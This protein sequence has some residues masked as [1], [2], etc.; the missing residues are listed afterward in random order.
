MA[1]GSARQGRLVRWAS[2]RPVVVAA[3][4]YAILALGFVSP[5]LFT[6]RT[7]S[8]SDLLWF[9]TPYATSKPADL[10]RPANPELYDEALYFQPWLQ[11]TRAHGLNTPLW[12]PHQLAGEPLL[13]TA[14][15]TPYAPFYLPIYLLPFWTGLAVA[16]ALKL[17]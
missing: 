16:A 15:G 2:G 9:T 6:G 11:Y 7:L 5:A 3:I 10:K 8:S 1:E 12:N 13:G 14:D 17:F 4:V